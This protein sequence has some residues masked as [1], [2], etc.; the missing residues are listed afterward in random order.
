MSKLNPNAEPFSPEHK[1]IDVSI[2][3]KRVDILTDITENLSRQSS[4]L[5]KLIREERDKNDKLKAM[6][7]EMF[8]PMIISKCDECK[9]KGYIQ[10]F[11]GSKIENRT[12]VCTRQTKQL[13]EILRCE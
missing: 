11:I 2:L 8:L 1:E 9:G 12:C 7:V 5:F 10:D 4:A 13:K 6:L 3:L